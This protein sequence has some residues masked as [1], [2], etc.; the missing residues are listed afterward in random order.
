MYIVCVYKPNSVSRILR[1][2]S[3][4]SSPSITFGVKRHSPTPT[5]ASLHHLLSR[6]I[7][8]P[9]IGYGSMISIP[10]W[11]HRDNAK[12]GVGAR[13]CTL[14]RILPFHLSSRLESSSPKPFSLGVYLQNLSASETPKPFGLRDASCLSSE[15][16]LLAPLSRHR[17]G[18]GCYLR[19]SLM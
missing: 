12:V 6:I 13:P 5:L 2:D 17:R 19:R 8:Q 18:D 15:A 9:E 16:S 3:H 11:Q 10:T 1:D 4:L 7:A 14:V